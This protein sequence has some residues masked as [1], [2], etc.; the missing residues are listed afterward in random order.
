MQIVRRLTVFV[1]CALFLYAA[2]LAPVRPALATHVANDQPGITPAL[3]I[4]N[5]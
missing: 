3:T 1:S 4:Y 5:Q 2:W